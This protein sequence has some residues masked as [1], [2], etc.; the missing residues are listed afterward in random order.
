MGFSRENTRLFRFSDCTC[1]A[2]ASS[3]VSTRFI[4]HPSTTSSASRSTV[5]P[6]SERTIAK[7][8]SRL[9]ATACSTRVKVFG[10][11]C[12]HQTGKTYRSVVNAQLCLHLHVFCALGGWE[13]RAKLWQLSLLYSR[14]SLRLHRETHSVPDWLALQLHTH[15]RCV[16]QPKRCA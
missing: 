7:I 10:S 12:L 5:S 1:T 2:L 11:L 15:F 9:T 14:L 13:L 16:L 6:P 8:D 3:S 4:A